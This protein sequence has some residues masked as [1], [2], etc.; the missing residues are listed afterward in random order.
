MISLLCYILKNHDV[1]TNFS[2]YSKDSKHD[3]ILNENMAHVIR[4]HRVLNKKLDETLTQINGNNNN[5][6]LNLNNIDINSFNKKKRNNVLSPGTV[7]KS[8][9]DIVD[10][11]KKNELNKNELNKN[12]LINHIKIHNINNNLNQA[13][14]NDLIKQ[15]ESHLIKMPIFKQEKN[16]N[17]YQ[18]MGNNM[19]MH[20][21]LNRINNNFIQ[22]EE[23]T[24][25]QSLKDLERII[26]IDLK[27][28]PL[29]LIIQR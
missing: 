10:F 18:F 3:L 8:H 6:N 14:E 13:P 7:E 15:D 21:N 25:E 4:H 2:A 1:N 12:A 26:H 27:V 24:V 16:Q 22:T 5:N 19:N 20:N 11:Y 17:N 9:V 28:K 23:L 29:K